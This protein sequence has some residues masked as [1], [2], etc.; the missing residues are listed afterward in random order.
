MSEFG[1][2]IAEAYDH[3]AVEFAQINAEMP[4]QLLEMGTQLLA[5]LGPAPRILDLGCGSGRDMAWLEAQGAVVTGV[6]LS[7]G[8]LEQARRIVTGTLRQMDM[9]ELDFPAVSF[10]AV[11]CCA[12]LLH[13]PKATA[14]DVLAQIRTLLT[15]AGML[16]L[17]VQEG[18]GEVWERGGPFGR[19]R[20]FFARY[21]REEIAV[22]LTEA[23]FTT[24]ECAS[25]R[26]HGRSWLHTLATVRS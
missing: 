2:Q 22:L 4:Q 18:S 24:L 9:C 15:A 26:A 13:I 20:R 8:M 10:D 3:A 1:H 11:W 6:D 21:T 12:S 14:P 7:A 5:R 23:C 16:F 17:A 19:H 25:G